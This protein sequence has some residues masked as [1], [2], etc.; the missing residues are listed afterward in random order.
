MLWKKG[1]WETRLLFV[2]GLAGIFLVVGLTI[3]FGYFDVVS[4]AERLQ[5][6]EGLS[7]NERQ[8][9]NSYQGKTWALLYKLGLNYLLATQAV[10]LGTGCLMTTCPYMPSRSSADLFTYSLPASR[11]KVLVSQ[12]VVGFGEM[13]LTALLPALLLPIIASL[14]GQWFSWSDTLIYTLLMIFG[15]AVIFS[16]A[17][18]L[19]VI[20]GNWFFVLV[21]VELVV[22]AMWMWMSFRLLNERPWWNLF[23]LMAGESYFFHG[24]IPWPGLLISLI[25][26][27][28][29]LFAAVRIYERRDL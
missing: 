11:R 2:F 29:F 12:A 5:R 13:L 6:S 27:A 8:A 4:W 23:G 7:V 16:C 10:P 22:L 25:L 26:S 15:G 20:F 28:V 19:T 1:W 21:L 9:L 24:R 17:F 14:Q 18:L 3:G